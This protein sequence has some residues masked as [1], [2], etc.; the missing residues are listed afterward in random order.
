MDKKPVDGNILDSI[1]SDEES[2][3]HFEPV[4]ALPEGLVEKTLKRV[5]PATALTEDVSSLRFRHRVEELTGK[6]YN[7]PADSL[8]Y[9]LGTWFYRTFN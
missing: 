5:E 4:P 8:V 9:R 6:P 2:D 3:M 7:P 1:V